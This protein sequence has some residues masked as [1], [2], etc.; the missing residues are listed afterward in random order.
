MTNDKIYMSKSPLKTRLPY[1][2][3]TYR[4]LTSSCNKKKSEYHFKL[5]LTAK[6]FSILFLLVGLSILRPHS[7]LSLLSFL[8][9]IVMIGV[10]IFQ[11]IYI[12][13]KRSHFNFIEKKFY[14][15]NGNS[16]DFNEIQGLQ[17]LEYGEDTNIRRVKYQ[18]NLVL[19]GL[20]NNRINLIES[21]SLPF[22]K[23]E[24]NRLSNLI[25]KPAFDDTTERTKF[26]SSFLLRFLFIA[27]I[28][29]IMFYISVGHMFFPI[30]L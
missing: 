29:L 8:V 30:K 17:L 14:Q 20:A 21:Y 19:D 13:S 18:L 28:T 22:I 10:A 4:E 1:I 25:N 24:L 7:E 23:K 9:A 26:H 11:W 3:I 2:Y 12:K 27:T 6:L 5:S 16:Y 15:D